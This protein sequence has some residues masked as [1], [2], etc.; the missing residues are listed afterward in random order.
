MIIFSDLGMAEAA[1]ESKAVNRSPDE[2]FPP[3]HGP[4][5]G[6]D[7]GPGCGEA[8]VPCGQGVF[9]ALVEAGED[10]GILRRMLCKMVHVSGMLTCAEEHQRSGGP[11]GGVTTRLGP[12]V[13]LD[14][15]DAYIAR[16]RGPAAS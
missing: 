6:F 12:H 7:G 1:G 15:L 9:Q 3:D 4:S 2:S 8:G 10:P 11:S 5:D 14:S 13:S 16:E